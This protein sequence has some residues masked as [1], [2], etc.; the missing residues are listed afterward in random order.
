M[1][2]TT[3]AA[4]ASAGASPEIKRDLP[5]VANA[6]SNIPANYNPD[7][8][9]D[10]NRDIQTPIL[11][12]IN[13]VGPL[14][15]KFPKNVGELVLGDVLLGEAITVVPVAKHK[16]YV[17]VRRNGTDLK[18]GDGIVPRVF[19]SAREAADAGYA[20]DFNREN[21][22]ASRVE[23]AAQMAFLVQGPKDD[24]SGEFYYTAPDGTIWGIG[25]TTL[26]RGSYRDVYRLINSRS[27]RPGA[28]V[29]DTK[30]TIS[31]FHKEDSVKQQDWFEWTAKA[32]GKL[33]PDFVTWIETELGARLAK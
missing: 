13:K 7:Q 20:V 15:K 6:A 32:E 23:E 17:E 18:F 8:Y 2:K 28:K 27:S 5:A 30:Y 29:Y 19:S 24:K 25:Q 11:G 16:I 12:L 1:A 3:I 31:S 33:D 9:D 26:R 10:P 22:L 21:P 14:S 4:P